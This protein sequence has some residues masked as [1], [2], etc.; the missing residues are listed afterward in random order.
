MNGIEK[1]KEKK[2]RENL[3][4]KILEIKKPTEVDI[5]GLGLY[6]VYSLEDVVFIVTEILKKE[7]DV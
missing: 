3:E 2:G 6:D 5:Q 1:Q 7:K 4:E